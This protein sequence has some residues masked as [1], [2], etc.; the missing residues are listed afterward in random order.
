MKRRL[1]ILLAIGSL[2]LC[3]AAASLWA[4]SRSTADYL[5]YTWDRRGGRGE[6]VVASRGGGLRLELRTASSSVDRLR[7]RVNRDHDPRQGPPDWPE[8]W[9]ESPPRLRWERVD[10]PPVTDWALVLN[11]GVVR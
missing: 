5:V 2:L 8:L 3:A 6:W 7:V 11:R 9:D 1:L 4:R 10:V